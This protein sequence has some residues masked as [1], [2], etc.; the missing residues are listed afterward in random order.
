METLININL[1]KEEM[2]YSEYN[3]QKLSRSL[4][5]YIIHECYGE[6]IKNN[7]VIN[8]YCDFKITKDDE[9]K[10]INMIRTNYQM[11]I[12]DEEFYLNQEYGKEII[13]F[14]VG[15][16]LLVLYYIIF[17]KVVLFSE[18]ILIL[19]WLAIWESTSN[20]LFVIGN[21]KLKIT[22][23]KKIKEAQINFIDNKKSLK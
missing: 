2:F 19:G 4:S 23:L 17:N 14:G 21:K 8:I 12:Q 16:I 3:N 7:I 20:Y 22:R 15:I 10:M 9:E 1:D 13:L 5:D 11:Y 18:I 6:P